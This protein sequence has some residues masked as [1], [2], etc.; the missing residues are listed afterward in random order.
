MEGC[1][2]YTICGDPLFFAPEIVNQNGYDYAADLWA[3]G[4][5]IYEI[6]EGSTPFGTS[7]M[8]E[9]AIFK[10]IAGFKGT[11]KYSK[12]T[13]AAQELI[14][15]LLRVSSEDRCGYR[16]WDAFKGRALFTGSTFFFLTAL[17]YI[18]FITRLSVCYGC[19]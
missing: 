16:Q 14:N 19:A 4:V 18:H 9:T 3:L 12:A 5:L 10:T 1:K 11:V 17:Y 2:N 7:E 8:E 13:A 15:S 6:Y